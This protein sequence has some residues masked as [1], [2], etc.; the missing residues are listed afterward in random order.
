[1]AKRLLK[2]TAPDAP[3]PLPARGKEEEPEYVT[4]KGAEPVAKQG[5]WASSLGLCTKCKTMAAHSMVD[6]LCYNCHKA[7][8]GFEYDEEK[9]KWLKSKKAR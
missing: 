3:K 9:K 5:D 4:C 1:M 7:V 6:K 8:E 2:R